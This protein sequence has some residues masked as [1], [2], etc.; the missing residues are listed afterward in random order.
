MKPLYV[1]KTKDVYSINDHEVLLKFKDDMTGKDGVFDPGSNEVGLSIDGMGRLNLR[2]T[3]FFMDQ[4]AQ[5]G[6]LTH[7]VS[8]DLEKGEMVVKKCQPFGKGLEVIFRHFAVGSFVRRYG[9]YAKDMMPL[10]NYVEMTLKDDKRQDPLITKEALVMLGLMSDSEYD[11]LVVQTKR[12]ATIIT[13][14]LAKKNLELIDIKLEFGKTSDG[15]IVLIDELSS[16]NMRVYQEGHKIDP[17]D[18]S[19]LILS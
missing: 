8:T 17:I 6:I 11:Y 10:D 2:V 15:Q 7:V 1:G 5:A 13:N 9:L 19:N 16:G 18:L 14:I 3:N 4:L 12:I